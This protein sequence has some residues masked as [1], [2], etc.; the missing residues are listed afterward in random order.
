M[1]IVRIKDIFVKD[2]TIELRQKYAMGGIVLFAAT[3]VFIIFKSFN[4]ISPR[5]WAILLWIVML[6]AGLN[7]IVKSFLQEKK[8]TYLYYYTLFD[9]MELILARLLYNYLFMM[10][11]FGVVVFFMSLFSGYPVKDSMLFLGGSA[12]GLFGISV[13]FTFVSVITASGQGNTT[14][15]SVL[16]LPLVLPSVLLLLKV[17]AVSIRLINDTAVG[18]DIWMLAGVDLLLTGVMVW[19]FPVLWRS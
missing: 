9:P 16:A 1:N 3:I 4:D 18:E 14:L 12:L 5:E 13:V 6:F 17:T 11:L 7:A 2:V 19:L 8:E 15:M 10:L